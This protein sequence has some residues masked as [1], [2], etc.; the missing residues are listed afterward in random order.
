LLHG[1]CPSMSL[2]CHTEAAMAEV[3]AAVHAVMLCKE[4]GYANIIF[5]GDTL[6]VIKAIE[7]TDLC[8]ST[9]NVWIKDNL[10][11]IKCLGF[12]CVITL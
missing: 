3:L 8:L 12:I 6:Q 4:M 1:V 2:E 11:M 5:E 7:T 10:I 9:T